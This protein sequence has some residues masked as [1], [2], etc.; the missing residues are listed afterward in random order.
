MA[1][2]LQKPG[3]SGLKKFLKAIVLFVVILLGIVVVVFGLLVGVC[4][5]GARR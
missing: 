3:D 5:L 4:F 1:N 2:E